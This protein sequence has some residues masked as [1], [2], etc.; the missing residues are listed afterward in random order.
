M[1]G[2]LKFTDQ[3]LDSML[4]AMGVKVGKLHTV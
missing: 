4:F 2:S 3:K 1:M